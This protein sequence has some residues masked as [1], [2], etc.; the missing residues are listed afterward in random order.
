MSGKSEPLAAAAASSQIHSKLV[1][2]VW[3]WGRNDGATPPRAEVDDLKAP[4]V[5]PERGKTRI[6]TS[7][8]GVTRNK[9]SLA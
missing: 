9:G 5:T 8:S 3:E 1:T 7:R 4:D 6:V 2:T